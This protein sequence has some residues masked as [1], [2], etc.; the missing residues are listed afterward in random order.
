MEIVNQALPVNDLDNDITDA[1]Y[2]SIE[3]F[4]KRIS[5]EDKAI[6]IQEISKQAN[7]QADDEL[8]DSDDIK[9]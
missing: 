5:E 4:N 8:K 1:A 6:I 3:K 2:E 9:E 7:L